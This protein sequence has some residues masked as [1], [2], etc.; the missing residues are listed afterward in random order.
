V[1]H[2]IC[3]EALRGEKG[4]PETRLGET[5]SADGFDFVVSDEM[6]EGCNLYVDHCALLSPPGQTSWVEERVDLA[7]LWDGNPPEPIF[8]TA[9]FITYD[10]DED[11]M[12][13]CDLKYGR[14]DVDPTENPQ[15]MAYALGALLSLGLSPLHIDIYIIQPRGQSHSGVKHWRTTALDLMVWGNEVLKPGVAEMQKASAGL[16]PGDHCLFCPSK[17]GCPALRDLSKSVSKTQF[18]AV[19]PPAGDMTDQ[20]LSDVLQKAEVINV[21]INAVRAEASHRLDRGAKVPGFKLVPKRAMRKFVNPEWVRGEVLN[22]PEQFADPE[23]L[24]KKTVV[25]PTQFQKIDPGNYEKLME[26]GEISAV[27]SGTTLVSD[28]DPRGALVAQEAK[29][30]FGKV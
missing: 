16:T 5:L 11:V 18:S 14:K 4:L 20:E 9:D 22:H 28:F 7:G 13:I 21:W 2:E 23:K 15:A 30:Q 10:P 26:S 25:T 29:S 27:S 12:S 17:S 19:P 1:A 24:I 3:E 8:G 6:V